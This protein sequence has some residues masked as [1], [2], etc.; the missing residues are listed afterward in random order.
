[1]HKHFVKAFL[2]L[3]QMGEKKRLGLSNALRS[4][5]RNRPWPL[6]KCEQASASDFTRAALVLNC[7]S[8]F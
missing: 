4:A 6:L 1:L 8:V 7:E 5:K 3:R 2:P